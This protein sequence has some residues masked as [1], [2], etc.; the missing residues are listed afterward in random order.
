MSVDCKVIQSKE[1]LGKKIDGV[2][3]TLYKITISEKNIL[4]RGHYGTV[5]EGI[6]K[7]GKKFAVKVMKIEDTE[8]LLENERQVRL[9]NKVNKMF[10][11]NGLRLSP[12]VHHCDFICDSFKSGDKYCKGKQIIVMDL[13]EPIVPA[14]LSDDEI[15]ILIADALVNYEILVDN[16]LYFFDVKM[17]N[18]VIQRI[19][20]GKCELVN[21]QTIDL[22]STFLFSHEEMKDGILHKLSSSFKSLIYDYKTL[23]QFLFMVHLLRKYQK[24]N[25]TNSLK[26]LIKPLDNRRELIGDYKRMRKLMVSFYDYN[27]DK[28]SKKERRFRNLTKKYITGAV[29]K[30]LSGDKIMR[31]LDELFIF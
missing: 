15:R 24:E 17:S 26:K 19:T 28:L 9:Q 18:N 4:G 12:P 7:S 16:K 31:Y 11:D 30:D 23:C 21:L 22:D 27:R 14:D 20:K 2:I 25:G 5:Y 13:R 29:E 3:K 1:L 8:T 6:N 10:K